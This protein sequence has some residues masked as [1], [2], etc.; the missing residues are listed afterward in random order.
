MIKIFRFFLLVFSLLL[1][2]QTLTLQKVN[3]QSTGPK[4]AFDTDRDGNKEIYL[5]DMDGS[6]PVN[7]TNAKGDDSSPLWS[8]DGKQ[9]LFVSTRDGNREVYAMD[10]DGSN[11]TNL[12]NNKAEDYAPSWSPDGKQ[13]LF[14]STRA[15]TAHVF[16]MQ[17]DGS[18]PIQLTKTG[19]VMSP[20]WSPDGKYIS[21]VLAGANAKMNMNAS[22]ISISG[23]TV[24]VS[25]MNPKGGNVG[26]LSN[27]HFYYTGPVWSPDSK[28]LAILA[29]VGQ[30]GGYFTFS[31]T[32]ARGSELQV[33]FIPYNPS[34]SPDG[35]HLVYGLRQM[36]IMDVEKN[37]KHQLTDKLFAFNI[38]TTALAGIGKN[39]QI[40]D[41]TGIPGAPVWSADSEQILFTNQESTNFDIYIINADGTDLT[42]LTD[43]PAQD[44]NASLQPLPQ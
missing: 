34:W 38:L 22:G 30:K 7:L 44:M 11:Q 36:Y 24:T 8:P 17:A 29:V 12:T 39:G 23:N 33:E 31:P 16:V 18:K 4:I 43:N 41:L 35:K 28:K 9:I 14:T 20:Q 25:V 27:V 42:N 15:K 32:G 6:N 37:T 2:L 10:T 5:M 26:K 21:Y 3:A 19:P 1:S 40:Y 13:I